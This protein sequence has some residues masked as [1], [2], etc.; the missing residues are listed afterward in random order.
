MPGSAKPIVVL[1][2]VNIDLVA[3]AKRVPAQGETVSGRDPRIEHGGKC[4]NRWGALLANAGSNVQLTRLDPALIAA[5]VKLG[6]AP[7]L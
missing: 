6:I 3:T 1:G 4:A 2:S 5:P 7:K